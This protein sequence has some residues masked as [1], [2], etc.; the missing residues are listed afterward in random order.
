M[1][2]HLLAP[3]QIGTMTLA[4]RVVMAPMGVEIVGADGMANDEVVAYYEER[5][6]GG[7]GLLITEVAAFAY[8]HGAN[9]VHQL[10]VSD[11]RYVPALRRLTD[12]VHAHGAKIAIQLVHHGKISRVD[13]AN[14]DPVMV[15]SIPQW[16]GSLDMI[17][18]LSIDE[19]MAMAAA[20]GGAESK[21]QYHPMTTDDIAAITEQLGDAVG[22]ARDAGFD[23]VEIHGAHGY[24]FS[25]F[26]SAQWNH[27]TDE[28]GGPIENRA[29]FLCEAIAEA[30]ARAGA[31]FPVWTRL[32][33][34]EYRTPDGI[35][36]DECQQTARLAVA[37]GAD[38]I[39]LSAYGDMTSGQAF[40]DGTLPDRE[41]KHAALSGKLTRELAVPVIGVGRIRPAVGDEMIAHRKADLVAMGRQL[42]A[43][44]ATA[45]KVADERVEEIRPCINCY[46][47][48]AQPFFD[49]KVKCAVNPVLGR[50]AELADV[51][52]TA[53]PDPKRIVVVGGGPAGLE[54]A[55]VASL[56]GHHVTVIERGDHIGGALRFAAL[57]YEPNLRLL[58][59]Y[60]HEMDRLDVDIRTG[61]EATADRVAALAPDRVVVATG[62]ARSRSTLPGADRRHVFD[63]DDLRDLLTGSGDGSAAKK[64]P[65]PVRTAIA[66]G[67]R[68]GVLADPGQVARLSERYMPVGKRAVIIGGGLVGAELAEFLIDRGREVTVLEE[69]DKLA[70][71]MA[72]PRRWRVLGDL[73]TH[74]ASLHTGVRDVEIEADVVRWTTDDGSATAAADTVVIA[75]LV[76]GDR[77][78]ADAFR[79]AGLD[80][81]VIGDADGIGYLEGAIHAG[82]HTAAA[83]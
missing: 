13:V 5:A 75:T 82:W 81:I 79:A 40:T 64:V 23:A 29:R 76:D 49:R 20:S 68:I 32:D 46:V 35:T 72:H 36:F 3:V 78:V 52:R 45:A 53:A 7:A 6:R 60:E 1:Y 50:E 57:L 66:V 31:D 77:S 41:A 11:D 8:P 27:R 44:P 55:R 26:L 15:P 48:V 62:S 2:D 33:A 73:R 83:F 10:A 63:G 69:G 47:C 25:G 59:W 80:P 12:A 9:S 21:P 4:N 61:E 58:R 65:L 28:Y 43:D 70:L 54:V 42:L 51:E 24:L 18:D 30:K 67:R 22:R 34:L 39:H 71:E 14:G 74:G 37:A 17:H 19:L 38:A 56:R 16:P